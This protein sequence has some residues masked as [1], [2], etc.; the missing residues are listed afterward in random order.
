M[1]RTN[2]TY[3]NMK[4]EIVLLDLFAGYGGA[5]LSVKSAG[6][7]ITKSYI[8][9]ID[10][11]ALKVLKKNF[12][13]AVFV[14]DVRNLNPKDFLDVNL[15]C[16]GSPCQSFSMAGKRKGMSTTTNV[17]VYTLEQYE[18]LKAEGFEFEGQSY[19]FWEVDRLI[20]G[21]TKLQKKKGLPVADFVVENVKMTKKWENILSSALGV[22]PVK[23]D[24]AL[25]SAQSRVRLFWGS[26]PTITIPK[27]KGISL[28]DVIENAV[29][30]AGFRG[31]KM[32]KQDFYSYP[33]TVRK[34]NKSNCVVTK[35]GSNVTNGQGHGTGYY[36]DK[37]NKIHKLTIEQGEMLMGLKPG[38]THVDGIT[39][40]AREKMCGNGWSIP[41]GS[42]VIKSLLKDK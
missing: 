14:G 30:G 35:F 39:K 10:P 33:L 8:S 41:V 29:N 13:K 22:K 32:N 1:Y 6:F 28:S 34:D 5:E 18:K 31:R 12:P 37:R 27:D 15:I 2:K 16:A 40:T 7:K 9:E 3:N 42:H 26:R 17:E 24:A 23:I 38:H 19:L 21:I 4:K 25:L 11:N 36:V 20:K